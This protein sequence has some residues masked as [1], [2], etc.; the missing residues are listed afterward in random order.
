MRLW[1]EIEAEIKHHVSTNWVG[2]DPKRRMFA[3][4]YIEEYNHRKAAERAGFQPARGLSLTREPVTAA[5]IA[6]LQEQM[7]VRT[8]I[9]TDFIRTKWAEIL[10]KLMGE[11]EVPL[12]DKDGVSYTGKKFHASEAVRAL[13]ELSKSTKF[14]SEGSGSG[15]SVSINIDL[16]ALGINTGVTIEGEKE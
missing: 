13:T 6:Y 14:Y 8:A 2:F 7:Q 3:Y 12:I 11:E 15:A 1:K 5:L 4:Y 9:N 16:G 10:P